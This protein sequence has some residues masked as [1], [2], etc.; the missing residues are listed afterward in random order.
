MTSR[1][2]RVVSRCRSL[3]RRRT[4]DDPVLI[5]GEHL[6]TEALD[7]GIEVELVLTDGSHPALCQRAR[8]AGASVYEAS[9]TVLDAASPVRTPSG[10]VAAARWRP[11]ALPSVLGGDQALVVGL[12]DVQDPGNVGA[13]IRSAHGLGAT[14]VLVLGESADPGGWKALRGS[15]G[16]LFRIPV[17]RGTIEDVMVEA[18]RTPIP[19]AAAVPT[20]GEPIASLDLSPPRLMLFGHEGS[21]LA[22][23][24]A[25]SC[26]VRFSIPM[27]AKAESL[28]VAVTV[29]LALWEAGRSRRRGGR[30]LR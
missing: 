30:T 10:L 15:M 12:V 9:A 26:D 19:L 13:A 28:N 1:G 11:A 4:R 16:S 3:A 17:A 18:R 23:H 22:A 24:V 2:H 14:G 7:A 6:L 20:G 21:G 8:Q 29:A 25:D 5:D 27:A